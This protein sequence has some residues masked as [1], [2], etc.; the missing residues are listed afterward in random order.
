MLGAPSLLWELERHCAVE[1]E[2][3]KWGGTQG[4]VGGPAGSIIRAAESQAME[5]D[6]T[7]T[8][9]QIPAETARILEE[10]GSV[11]E[12]QSTPRSAGS[13]LVSAAAGA[14]PSTYRQ[15]CLGS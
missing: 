5:G 13:L 11:V 1:A 7:R 4:S 3:F 8:P 2:R 10:A 15:P 12:P 14:E 6:A 9:T